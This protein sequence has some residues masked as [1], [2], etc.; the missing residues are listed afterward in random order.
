MI[1][2]ASQEVASYSLFKG[3]LT[4]RNRQY[5]HPECKDRFSGLNGSGSHCLMRGHARQTLRR[6]R[7]SDRRAVSCYEAKILLTRSHELESK[8]NHG[9]ST[10][11]RLLTLDS[12]GMGSMY[13][14]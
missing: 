6:Q 10:D 14:C 12:I 3:Q 8:S 4:Q 13:H 1:G 9:E 2:E 5:E 7:N 11:R